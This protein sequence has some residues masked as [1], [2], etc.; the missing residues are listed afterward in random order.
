MVTPGAG[1]DVPLTD[2]DQGLKQK[3][4]RMPK[5]NGGEFAASQGIGAVTLGSPSW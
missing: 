3:E 5:R 2:P 1:V 4:E